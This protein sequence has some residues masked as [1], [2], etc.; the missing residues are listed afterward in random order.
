MVRI[1]WIFPSQ[2]PDLGRKTALGSVL[3]LFAHQI[4]TIDDFIPTIEILTPVTDVGAGGLSNALPE[5]L[6]DTDLGSIFELR[7]ID[8]ADRGM[9][10]VMFSPNFFHFSK[11]FAVRH[12]SR[13]SES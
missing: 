5:L 6:H 2:V 13:I 4:C 7:D 8:N 1:P 10:Y 11:Y 12:T 9:R 3:S